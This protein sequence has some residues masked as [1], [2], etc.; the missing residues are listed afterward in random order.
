MSEIS[1]EAWDAARRRLTPVVASPPIALTSIPARRG[2]RVVVVVGPGLL[3]A[4][5][6]RGLLAL[7]GITGATVVNT[8]GAKGLFRWDDPLHGAT[9]GLQVDDAAL[10]EITTAD[11]VV[12]AG[13][14]PTESLTLTTA[15]EARAAAEPDTVIDVHPAH[16]AVAAGGW[17]PAPVAGG[18][19]PIYDRIAGVVGPLYTAG[20]DASG[21]VFPPRAAAALASSLPEVGLVVA[22]PGPT[23]FWLGRTFPTTEPGSVIVTTGDPAGTAEAVGLL[24]ARAGRPTTLVLGE[25]ARADEVLDAV[26]AE[27]LPLTVEV[28][29][30]PGAEA[31]PRTRAVAVD[32]SAL[33]PLV[34]VAGE[35]DP[36]IWPGRAP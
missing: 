18:R 36:A 35:P 4:R 25:G 31:D 8:V 17:P 9:V 12:T 3:A 19:P 16:L 29:T 7:A 11:L 6:Q 24:A 22:P 26:A 2:A 32:W 13:L 14:D 10:A 27:A 15:L 34:E 33:D 23:G 28:W 21:A 5:A 30:R 1:T 20:P